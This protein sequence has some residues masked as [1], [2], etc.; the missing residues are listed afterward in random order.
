M[1][2]RVYNKPMLMV[3][4][5]VPQEYVAACETYKIACLWSLCNDEQELW[6]DQIRKHRGDNCGSIDNNV[7]VTNKNGVILSTMF[8]NHVLHLRPQLIVSLFILCFLSGIQ[9]HFKTFDHRCN[10]FQNG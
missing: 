7:V 8:M 2:K 10:S 5:F 4:A 3:E 1:E 6:N 9:L